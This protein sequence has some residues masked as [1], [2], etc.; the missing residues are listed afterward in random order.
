MKKLKTLL[1]TVLVITTLGLTACLDDDAGS[2]GFA[3]S[4]S[5]KPNPGGVASAPAPLSLVLDNKINSNPHY[6]YFSY[7]AT[8]NEKLIINTNLTI[9][10]T[11]E[12]KNN[13]LLSPGTS[14]KP[15]SHSTQIHIYNERLERLEGNCGDELTFTAPY[16]GDFII[17]FEFPSHGPGFF[18]AAIFNDNLPLPTKPLGTPSDPKN[19]NFTVSGN[20]I[21]NNP[22]YNYYKYSAIKDEKLIL[23]VNLDTP[24]TVEDRTNCLDEPGKA[25]IP[26]KFNTQIHVYDES[27]NRITG[28]CGDELTFTAPYKGNFIIHFDF[29]YNKPTS[30]NASEIK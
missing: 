25:T 29:P 11:D 22:H 30:F 27:L 20:N 13:C 26:S 4:S 15:S 19:I 12:D 10:L 9:P 14:S 2:D 1:F 28:N 24:L 5:T 21:N 7:P 17:N 8:K 16:T 23:H 3:S 6:N 18:N